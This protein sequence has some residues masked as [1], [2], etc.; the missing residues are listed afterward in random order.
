MDTPAAQHSILSLD[1]DPIILKVLDDLVV[2][3]GYK[4]VVTSSA[5]EA[6]HLA[7]ERKFA[8]VI[9]D[10]NMPDMLGADLL[11]RFARIQPTTSRI[12]IT[13]IKSLDVVTA[14][15]NS[16]EIYR[17]VSKPWIS[18]E[19]IATLH[20]AV[21]RYEL[22]ESNHA[23]EK[24]TADLNQKL[25]EANAQLERQLRELEVGKKDI[26]DSHEALK[27]NFSRSLELCQRILS[28]FNPLLGEQAKAAAKICQIM[29]DTHYFDE[30]QKHVLDVSARL[31][32]IGLT[33]VPPG[34]MMAVQNNAEDMPPELKTVFLNHTIHG[35]TLASFVDLLKPVGDTIRA[36][37]EHFDGS[38]FPDGLAGEM[39]PWT[40]RCLAVVVYYVTCGLPHEHAVDR[41]LEQSGTIFDPDATR[42]FLRCAQAT[43]LPR[44]VR[45][46]MVDELDVGM[47]LAS[48]IYSPTGV[49]LVA[50]GYHLDE[51]TIKKIRNYNSSSALPRQLLVYC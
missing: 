23:L 17:F 38:G 12:L 45:E 13:G 19:M 36:H 15:V 16:G 30:E 40:A 18:A 44:L 43:L 26:H 31:Y 41:I 7:V 51:N 3:A 49:L 2:R 22:I 42:L 5:E 24:T 25:S 48:G 20:N 27:T 8:V 11:H 32:D 28:T 37:H 34:Y 14:A 29:A 1:D 10:H 9:A 33:T 35:Q 6:L 4:S 46:V 50:E 47:Q 21:Q 39:I